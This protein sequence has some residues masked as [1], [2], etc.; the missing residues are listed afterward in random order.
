MLRKPFEILAARAI[1][2]I[3]LLAPPVDCVFAEEPINVI[4]RPQSVEVSS[5]TRVRVTPLT[6]QPARDS[7]HLGDEGYILRCGDGGIV[8]RANSPA[9]FFYARQTLDQ[10]TDDAGTVPA[11]RIVDRPRFAYRGVLIDSARYVQS[12]DYLKRTNADK[13][14][15]LIER[16]G[17]R[18]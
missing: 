13:Y 11:V 8:V 17:L 2:A 3:S 15:T 1:L 18:K 7:D 16:L 10:L 4:P 6:T 9:G 14:K 12:V 5:A